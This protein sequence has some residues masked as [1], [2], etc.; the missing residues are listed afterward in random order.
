MRS[1]V[2]PDLTDVDVDRT[3]L[4]IAKV[5]VTQIRL[6]HPQLHADGL[7]SRHERGLVRQIRHAHLDVDDRLGCDAR[8]R[9]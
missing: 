8:D 3:R 7:D 4:R 5:D 1:H 2:L 6:A 9:T